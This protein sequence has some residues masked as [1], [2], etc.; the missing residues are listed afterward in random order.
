MRFVFALIGGSALGLA[1]GIGSVLYLTGLV[2]SK[3]RMGDTVEVGYWLGNF[4]IGTDADDPYTKAW[5][6][7][8][9]LL[10]L[11]REEAVYFTATQDMNG[12]RLQEKCSYSLE[13]RA[14]PG[15]WWSM[16]VY[17]KTGYLPKNDGQN[18]S[19]VTTGTESPE[20]WSVVLAP[21]KPVGGEAWI[22]TENAGDF[23]VTMRIYLP[24]PEFLADPEKVL[25]PPL[26]KPLTCS[27]EA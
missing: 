18:L 13:S 17:D 2:S 14:L 21:E 11:R 9:G 20:T 16:T 24:T 12:N 5:V 22:S 19:Y 10:A 1:I 8:Y 27:E 25:S 3:I 6:A 7:R 23:D 4:T 15:A 26:I